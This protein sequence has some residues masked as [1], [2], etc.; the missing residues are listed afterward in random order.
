MGSLAAAKRQ[1]LL[2]PAAPAQ[3]NGKNL[4]RIACAL[5]KPFGVDVVDAGT[6]AT[7][8]IDAQPEHGETVACS[9][10]PAGAGAGAGL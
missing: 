6:P 5:A 4:F 8:V 10:P 7:A 2:M 1:T 9:E 3:H